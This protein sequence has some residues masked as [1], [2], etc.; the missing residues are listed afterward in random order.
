MNLLRENSSYLDL[1]AMNRTAEQYWNQTRLDFHFWVIVLI[2]IWY[3][4]YIL[5]GAAFMRYTTFKMGSKYSHIGLVAIELLALA[6][7]KSHTIYDRNS[8][9]LFIFLLLLLFAVWK[10]YWYC[11]FQECFFFCFQIAISSWVMHRRQDVQLSTAQMVSVSWLVLHVLRWWEGVARANF[12][13]AMI[14]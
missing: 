4:F 3:I 14:R 7:Q 13:M 10:L 12:F 2:Y 11:L 1:F 6:C 9:G 5:P 8:Q